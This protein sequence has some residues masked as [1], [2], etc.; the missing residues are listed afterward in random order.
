MPS[1]EHI[2]LLTTPPW[3]DLRHRT[4]TIRLIVPAER[5]FEKGGLWK[6]RRVTA[7]SLPTKAENGWQNRLAIPVYPTS[8][9]STLRVSG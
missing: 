9:H 8:I 1:M 2:V 6:Y 4:D 3:I 7:T 5:K